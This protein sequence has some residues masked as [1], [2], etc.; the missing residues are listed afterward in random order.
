MTKFIHKVFDFKLGRVIEWHKK[1]DVSFDTLKDHNMILYQLT[2]IYIFRS[3]ILAVKTLF[4]SYMVGAIW[5]ILVQ[6][7]NQ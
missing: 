7:Q 1:N 6:I 4:I 2:T 5:F 3:L